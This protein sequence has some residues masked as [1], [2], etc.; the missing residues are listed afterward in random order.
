MQLSGW[1]FVIVGLIV[2]VASFIIGWPKMAI[3]VIVGVG[4]TLFG[5]IRLATNRGEH[6]AAKEHHAHHE[7][8]REFPEQRHNHQ[9]PKTCAMCKARNHPRANFCGHCGNRL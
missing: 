9:I 4:M 1:V 2:S 3:F 6:H 7:S 8:M 5:I